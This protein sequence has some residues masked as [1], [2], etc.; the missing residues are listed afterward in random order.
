MPEEK[1][2]PYSIVMTL[3]DKSHDLRDFGG[4]L[5]EVLEGSFGYVV[6][7]RPVLVVIP[8]YGDR[9]LLYHRTSLL[10]VQSEDV[11]PAE[12]VEL[13]PG[14]VARFNRNWLNI[15]RHY[16]ATSVDDVRAFEG[17]LCVVTGEV[18]NGELTVVLEGSVNMHCPSYC[19]QPVR[20]P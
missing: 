2:Y 6:Y 14:V 1:L 16:Q 19:L 20:V 3:T 12:D 4:E 5:I 8:E 11:V 15:A 9:P 10:K 17:D 13:Q 7:P 18:G